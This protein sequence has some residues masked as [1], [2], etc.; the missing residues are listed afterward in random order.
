MLPGAERMVGLFVNSLPLRIRIDAARPVI[1]LL[2]AV[3]DRQ[4]GV[5]RF[6][7]CSLT[8]IQSWSSVPRGEP[9]FESLFAFENFPLG[10]KLGEAVPEIAI[11]D[12]RLIED[13]LPADADRRSGR[14]TNL[15]GGG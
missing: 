10:D 6:D 13:S 15:Q 4:L 5:Q 12:A 11:C 3:Q 1:D 14:N 9:L 2:R 7:H 8:D